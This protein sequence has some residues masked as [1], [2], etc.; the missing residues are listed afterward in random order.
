[1]LGATVVVL[2][3]LTTTS[4]E[5]GRKRKRVPLLRQYNGN[6]H[7]LVGIIL[8]TFSIPT[9]ANIA[10]LL[11]LAILCYAGSVQCFRE[12][13]LKTSCLY[14][15][16]GICADG[17]IQICDMMLKR[18]VCPPIRSP[19]EDGWRKKRATTQGPKITTESELGPQNFVLPTDNIRLKCMGGTGHLTWKYESGPLP[20]FSR[21]EFVSTQNET[22]GLELVMRPIGDNAGGYSCVD[23]VNN[24]DTIYMNVISMESLYDDSVVGNGTGDVTL[25]CRQRFSPP[26]PLIWAFPNLTDIIPENYRKGDNRV[27]VT[28]LENGS[29]L[30]LLAA[31]R[32]GAVLGGYSCR[33]NTTGSSLPAYTVSQLK[34][35]YK[36][37]LYEATPDVR[38]EGSESVINGQPFVLK[39][40]IEGYSTDRIRFL[41]INETTNKKITLLDS[42]ISTLK[43]CEDST[44]EYCIRRIP[45]SAYKF[46]RQKVR[47]EENGQGFEV[48]ISL[49]ISE[50]RDKDQM[51][52]KENAQ[53]SRK[54][55]SIYSGCADIPYVWLLDT[56]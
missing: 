45:S 25:R 18:C 37:V 55:G 51:P 28:A 42:P 3:A 53:A 52:A 48:A 27:S 16:Y 32:S 13:N 4:T 22:Q 43:L 44:A 10:L 6:S 15:S 14:C 9:M 20:R 38:F 24:K 7:I 11:R 31:N 19:A 5:I 39:C 21:L 1:M 8:G 34:S 46:S 26:F 12:E 33:V 56:Q 41:K 50:I 47:P 49:H 40:I 36:V 35:I 29:A 30:H 2:N 17:Q 23:E 54:S